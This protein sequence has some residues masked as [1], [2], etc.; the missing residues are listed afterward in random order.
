MS[1]RDGSEGNPMLSG[2]GRHRNLMRA[3]MDDG[4]DVCSLY[5]CVLCRGER[6]PDPN[7]RTVAD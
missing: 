1:F 7:L 6:N 5:R 2:Q 4:A 3:E